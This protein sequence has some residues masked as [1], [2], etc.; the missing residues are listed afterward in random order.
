MGYFLLA[1]LYLSLIGCVTTKDEITLEKLQ[2]LRDQNEIHYDS[3]G[4]A[5]LNDIW[6]NK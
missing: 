4:N 6:E 2:S 1:F 5:Y 3:A